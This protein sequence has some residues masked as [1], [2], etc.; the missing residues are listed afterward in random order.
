MQ[1]VQKEDRPGTSL[2]NGVGLRRWL[3]YLPVAAYTCDPQGLINYFNRYASELWGRAPKLNDAADRFCGSFKLY[4]ADGS[5]IAHDECWM[6]LALERAEKYEGQE[7]VIERP[8]GSRRTVLAHANPIY[9]DT[10]NLVGAVNILVDISDQR[11]VEETQAR[12]AAIVESSDD[13][14]ISKTLDGRIVSW[15]TGAE[16]LFGYTAREAIGQSIMLIIPPERRD[17]E[18]LI[19]A[20]LCRGERIDHYETIRVSK[21]GRRID[22]SL[23]ISPVRDSRGNIVGAS[24]VA[25]D[26]T[27]RK[28]AEA[29]IVVLKDE[30]ATQLADLRRLHEMSTRL[31]TTLELKPMLEETLRTAAV[32]EGTEMGV[33]LLCED[34]RLEIG[35]SLGF[36]NP[37]LAAVAHMPFD[38]GPYGVSCQEPCRLVVEDVEVCPAFVPYRDVAR[39]AGFRALHH[40]PLVARTGKIIGALCTH[41]RAPHRPSDQ[42]MHL[43][44][45]CARQAVDYIE[46]ARLY[47]QVREADQRKEEFM[48]TLAHELRNPLAPLSNSVHTLGLVDV[49]SPEARQLREIMERQVNQMV[50]LV[51]D[52]LDMSRISRGK[53][54][55]RK[56][57]LELAT[58]IRTAVETSRPLIEEAGH[59]LDVDIPTE[60]V[61]LDADPVRLAQ[62]IS[63]LL[64]NA[65]KFMAKKGRIWLS[66]H[67]EGDQLVISVRDA[68][69]G[70]PPD[71]LRRIFDMFAQGD[72]RT[73]DARGGL[74]IGLTLARTLVERH[75]GRI[76]A[77]SEGPNK[78]SEFI[79]SLPLPNHVD[80]ITASA[81]ANHHSRPLETHRILIVD[82]TADA[83]YVLSKLLE[84]LGQEVRTA[85]SAATALRSIEADVPDLVISDLG[86]PG[87]D[88]YALARQLRNRPELDGVVLVALTGYGQE[89]DRQH[90]QEAGFDYHLVKPVSVDALRDLLASLDRCLTESDR[91]R[92][93]R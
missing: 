17:E 74:G 75:G 4:A 32:I 49:L 58:A 50:R 87:M 78:G 59:Q 22:I 54:E 48:A 40:T 39:R 35:A 69:I 38:D 80:G 1:P 12:L 63:N 24:K 44:D 47:Q 89:S 33:L 76:E 67:T 23:T 8:D 43:V 65:V 18:Q 45:L 6:A 13:A 82:D 5:P 56:E 62:V 28:R 15:N 55:L 53:L 46:N 77:R 3:D 19:L 61:L 68:G 92:T 10:G 70:I 27:A 26:I 14:I 31:S 9:D 11:H 57:R 79:V 51:D 64:N 52:L 72:T 84:A 21:E 90:T 25:R 86:M 81:S 71:M 37:F 20:R 91:S 34:N 93:C 85:H 88:G 16:R 60:P 36:E 73:G 66:A 83:V 30:L 2:H 7:I 42:E 41:F 29:A